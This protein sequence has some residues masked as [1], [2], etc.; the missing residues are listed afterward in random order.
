MRNIAIETC[1][2]LLAQMGVLPEEI[3]GNITIAGADPIVASPHH[4][5]AA[6][7]S[8]LAAHGA[9]I[10]AI[11]RMRS[12]R[13]Q[14]VSVD[15]RRA[16]VPGL[17][18]VF[19]V[20]QGGKRL[21]SPGA[22]GGR[23]FF[24][25]RDNRQIY[26]LRVPGSYVDMLLGLL[27]LLQ[28]SNDD[29]VVAKTVAGWHSAEL[30]DAI[31]ARKLVGVV[32]RRRDEWLDHAQ[33]QWL[34]SRPA[35]AIE[36]IGDAAPEPFGPAPRPLTGVRVLDVTHVLAG[37]AAARVL[38]EQGAD[39]LHIASHRHPD[40][41][42]KMIDTSFGKRS[43]YLD[44]DQD[45]DRH[46]LA[47]LIRECDVFVQSWRP[48]A[49]AKR[50]FGPRDIAALR[51]GV[52]CVSVSAYGGGGP[53]ASRGGYDP[54]GQVASGF[55]VEE[56]S[57]ETPALAPTGTMNDYIAAYLAAAGALGGLVRRAR[58]GGSYH[59]DVSLTRASMF[60]MELGLLDARPKPE[61]IFGL[62]PLPSDLR[63]TASPMGDVTYPA[64]ITDYSET[65]AYWQR[66]CGYFGADK[67]VWLPR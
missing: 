22:Y 40:T 19:A 59:I 30:E 37:P 35:I 11:W 23:H 28:C 52:V 47:N 7:A 54:V 49:L 43:A 13:G 32:V 31:A 46:T 33:G 6:S 67:P 24:R 18:T 58:E 2:R 48:G 57:F 63:V 12:G 39:V 21:R 41:A 3:A 66:P 5:G 50:G 65:K 9:A 25:T 8:A 60:V 20:A 42:D 64:P 14:D 15:L 10:A 55:A 51:P 1:H 44:L 26:L 53:W 34:A 45:S 29:A 61:Q 16:V 56:G 27:D 4:L 38:A 36:K 62:E 17:R